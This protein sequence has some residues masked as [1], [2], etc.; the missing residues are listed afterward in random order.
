MVT[1]I[2]GTWTREEDDLLRQGHQM[3]GN[4]WTMVSELVVKTRTDGQCL[5]RWGLLSEYKAKG[6]EIKYVKNHCSKREK[7][8]TLRQLIADS[9]DQEKKNQKLL[10]DNDLVV[11]GK[12]R[13]ALHTIEKNQQR[14]KNLG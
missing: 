11:L 6:R 1:L 12:P 9:V 10:A 13:D 7:V 14:I 4:Q 5:K 3:Y 2:K 8:Q